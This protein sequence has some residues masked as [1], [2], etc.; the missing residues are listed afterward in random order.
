MIVL[1]QNTVQ[2]IINTLGET[3]GQGYI[4]DN[5]IKS[6]QLTLKENYYIIQT[7]TQDENA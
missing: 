4:N 2:H 6:N 1:M 5:I 3:E 7:E